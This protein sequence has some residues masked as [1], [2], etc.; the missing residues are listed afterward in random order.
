MKQEFSSY[1]PKLRKMPCW[2]TSGGRRKHIKGRKIM[3]KDGCK[4]TG[5]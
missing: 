5:S 3:K 4:E 1:S 2:I